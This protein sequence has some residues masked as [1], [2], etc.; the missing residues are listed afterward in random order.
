M[1]PSSVS[2]GGG[3]FEGIKEGEHHLGGQHPS[4]PPTL[5][6]RLGC[7]QGNNRKR[8]SQVVDEDLIDGDNSSDIMTVAPPRRRSR[9]HDEG[10]DDIAV[11]EDDD[12]IHDN[13]KYWV[14][15]NISWREI[16]FLD[17]AT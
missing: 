3:D 7:S 5:M 6:S 17:R 10:V 13:G 4:S 8:S 2:S 11:P 16:V 14:L 1:S 9:S 12:E 15:D